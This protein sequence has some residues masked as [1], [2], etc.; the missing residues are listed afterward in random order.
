MDNFLEKLNIKNENNLFNNLSEKIQEMQNNYLN[1]NLNKI[2][3]SAIN[4]G[5]KSILPDFIEDQVIEIKDTI[6]NEGIK[7]GI[8]SLI[9]ST[10]DIGKTAIGIFTGNFEN[11]S[12]VELAVEKGGLIDGISDLLDLAIKTAQEKDLI[13]KSTAKNL[14]NGKNEILK[15]ITNSIENN[16]SDQ[17]KSIDKLNKYTENWNKAFENKNFNDMEKSIEKIEKEL[18][19]II[20]LENIIKNVRKIENI[21]NLIKNNDK[22]FDISALELELANKLY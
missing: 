15:T 22:N 8:D 11:I 5:I 3:D 17:I 14:K 9:N 10:I 12:Q 18:E 7:E 2:V 21:H 20:P 16:M 4:I 6:I 19:K 13:D 1:S